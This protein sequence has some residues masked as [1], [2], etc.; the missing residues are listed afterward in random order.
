M[1]PVSQMKADT[2]AIE[3]NLTMTADI[4]MHIVKLM[5]YFKHGKLLFASF[6][7]NGKVISNALVQK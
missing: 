1:L 6:R 5:L 7:C 2:I 4:P 3:G